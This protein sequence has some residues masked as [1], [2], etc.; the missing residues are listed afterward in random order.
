MKV[1]NFFNL[2]IWMRNNEV[3]AILDKTK[4]SGGD[5]MPFFPYKFGFKELNYCSGDAFGFCSI[6][7]KYSIPL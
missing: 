1:N 2:I 6:N 4:L 7:N 3:R 5:G